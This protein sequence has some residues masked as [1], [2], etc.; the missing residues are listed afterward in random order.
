MLNVYIKGL[1]DKVS[2]ILPLS[3]RERAGEQ[4]FLSVFL[5]GV[6]IEANGALELF[7][8]LQQSDRYITVLSKLIWIEKHSLEPVV[9]RREVFRMRKLLEEILTLGGGKNGC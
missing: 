1:I 4:C 6:L 7:P 2:K 9:L 3:E 8:E 5:E